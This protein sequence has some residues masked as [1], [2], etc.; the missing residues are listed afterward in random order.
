MSN[1]SRRTFLKNSLLTTGGAALLSGVQAKALSGRQRAMGRPLGANDRIR[2]A[3]AGINGQ[4]GRHV[5]FYAKLAKTHNVELTYL[6][7]PDSRLFESR[8]KILEDTAGYRPTHCVQDVR[9][10]LD[11]KSVDAVSIATPN[12]WHALLTIWAC[13]AGKDVLVEKPMCHNIH[14]GRIAVET[15]RKYGRVVRQ[16]N[17]SRDATVY[18]QI[19]AVV[20]SGKLGKLKVARGVC[21]KW[22]WNKISTRGNIGYAP[23][24]QPPRELDFNIWLGPASCRPYHANLV[25]YKW[26]WFWDF[27][28]GDLGN[29]GIN[30]VDIVRWAIPNSTLPKSVFSFGG[31]LGYQDQGEVA[32]TQMLIAD[33]GETKFIFETRGLK[34]EPFHDLHVGIILHLEGGMIVS[35]GVDYKFFPEGSTDTAQLPE[36]PFDMGPVDGEGEIRKFTNFLAVMR[37]RNFAELRSDV[38]DAHYSCALVHLANAS[39]RLG[40]KVP[41]RPQPEELT[42]DPD[43]KD[44]LDR[45]EEYLTPHG[46]SMEKDGFILGRKLHVDPASEQVIDDPQ[47][48][49][50]L[51][52]HYRKPFVV[53]DQA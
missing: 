9:H 12:H 43:I 28:N 29:Q 45:T 46:L 18:H 21:Y 31:R 3:M 4:G 5:E 47:A 38:L 53:P 16:G 7:D 25:H 1:Q 36:V 35:N 52:R 40:G 13:Q 27:G 17:Q 41:F 42:G 33:Y 20:R 44:V 50:L 2:V 49:A 24:T 10:A 37:N 22:G 11:D 32:S 19:M 39:I 26:H 34:T 23:H 6:A 15:A 30:E 48:N 51:T 8:T 14:E